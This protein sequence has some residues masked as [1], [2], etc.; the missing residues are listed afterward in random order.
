M[1]I[2]SIS[3]SSTLPH[4]TVPTVKLGFGI[5]GAGVAGQRYAKVLSETPEAELSAVVRSKTGDCAQIKSA[6]NVPCYHDLHQFLATPHMNAVCV[7]SPS[8]LHF[9][10][11][12]AALA[13][14]KHVLIEK[15]ITLDLEHADE[16]LTLATTK[17][18]KIGVMFQ[19][20]AD[21][22]FQRIQ[23]SISD[24]AI[25]EPLV[26][27]IVMPYHRPAAYYQE[28][29]WRGTTTLDG[30]GALM[31]QGIHLVD[32]ALWW[33]GSVARVAGLRAQLHHR[34]EVEDTVAV[35]M[36]FKSGALG[37][38]CG[39]T[40]SAVDDTHSITVVG[41]RGAFILKG[42]AIE[43]WNVPDVKPPPIPIEN[44]L[45]RSD[46]RR[47]I[48]MKNYSRV[49][50][51]FVHAIRRNNVPIISGQDARES[52]EVVRAAYES[53]AKNRIVSIP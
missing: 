35:S 21:P 15:P 13:A 41:T 50:Q 33:F 49:I 7:A 34:I 39:T 9:D 30:G 12:R 20:R 47:M 25:G 43:S 48:S 40:A 53:A 18:L 17:N 32:V 36:Q 8:G 5:I 52:L 22:V 16:L 2:R 19:R 24:G 28:A 4:P 27:N 26:L 44:E 3:G 45:G 1:S 11:A 23:Q 14:G 46:G 29:K 51:A 31:N 10:H 42:E 38:I 37:T 6:W